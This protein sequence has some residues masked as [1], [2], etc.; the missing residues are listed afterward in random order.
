MICKKT[1]R[2]DYDFELKLKLTNLIN[3]N[4]LK[5]HQKK[6]NLKKQNIKKIFYRNE[7]ETNLLCNS[8]RNLF[9]VR[10]FLLSLCQL[11]RESVKGVALGANDQNKEKKTEKVLVKIVFN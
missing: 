8:I 7:V 10:L 4:R 11:I 1:I 5:F 6:I 2:S 3:R 9:W